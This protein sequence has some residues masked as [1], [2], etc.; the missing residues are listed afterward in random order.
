MLLKSLSA[1]AEEAGT[2]LN[3][4]V[5]VSAELHLISESPGARFELRPLKKKV[6][7]SLQ[8]TVNQR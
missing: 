4:P 5:L 6:N 2:V 8:I 3:K 7:L 1:V